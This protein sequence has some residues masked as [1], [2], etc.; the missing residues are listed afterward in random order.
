LPVTAL[1]WN[2]ASGER[3]VVVPGILYDEMFPEYNYTYW[4]KNSLTF[5]FTAYG[6][7][8][9][10]KDPL[11]AGSWYGVGLTYPSVPVEDDGSG[12]AYV[13]EH[14]PEFLLFRLK[15]NEVPVMR[16]ISTGTLSTTFS[17]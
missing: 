8:V 15:I 9:T 10:D 7:T 3:Q 6:E 13:A 14:M 11:H 2:G 4:Q 17:P 5:G 1:S 16:L 12:A